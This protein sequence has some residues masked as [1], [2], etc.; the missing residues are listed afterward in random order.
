MGEGGVVALGIAEGFE[1]RHLHVVEFLRIVG[2][3]SGVFD[4]RCHAGEK[5][6]R[7]QCLAAGRDAPAPLPSRNAPQTPDR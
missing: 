5:L 7:D 4:R 3:V 1:G 6:L 2:A